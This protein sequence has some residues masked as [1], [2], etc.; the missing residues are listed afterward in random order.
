MISEIREVVLE[1]EP[2]WFEETLALYVTG[3]WVPIGAPYLDLNIFGS[4]VMIQR[5]QLIRYEQP[6]NIH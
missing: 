3:G 6:K 2:E 1:V 5:L 4:E